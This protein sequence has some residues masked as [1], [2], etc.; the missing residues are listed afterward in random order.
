MFLG[1]KLFFLVALKCAAAKKG[2]QS[3]D[4]GYAENGIGEYI[5]SLVTLKSAKDTTRNHQVTLIRLD[6]TKEST[7]FEGIASEIA[8]GNPENPLF[9]HS[10]R[11]TISP[12]K[13]H[14]S[15]MLVITMEATNS[16]RIKITNNIEL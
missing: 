7:V 14:A 10:S 2:L 8:K 13:V 4:F 12:F 11:Q 16:V 15:S 6:T 1:V 3:F 5:S 9:I